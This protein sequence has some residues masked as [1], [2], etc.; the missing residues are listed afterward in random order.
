MHEAVLRRVQAGRESISDRKRRAEN[1][2]LRHERQLRGSGMGPSAIIIPAG[3][4]GIRQRPTGFIS[5]P[6]PEV[7]V[8]LSLSAHVMNDLQMEKDYGGPPTPLFTRP[9]PPYRRGFPWKSVNNAIDKKTMP[10][11]I[12]RRA[13]HATRLLDLRA[14]MSLTLERRLADRF[15]PGAAAGGVRRPGRRA[16]QHGSP[17]KV[18][19]SPSIFGEPRRELATSLR[20]L[21]RARELVVSDPDIMGGDPVFRGTRVP[22]HLSRHFSRRVRPRRM[23]EGYPRLTAEMVRLAPLYAAAYPLRGGPVHSPGTT[24]RRPERPGKLAAIEVG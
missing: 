18:A 4:T 20:K 10:A 9:R 6:Q 11:V 12:G 14:L 3:M 23:I 8:R 21:R 13:G 1:A 16:A 7:C 15:V 17:S 24:R 19:S 2:C 5:I 22:V